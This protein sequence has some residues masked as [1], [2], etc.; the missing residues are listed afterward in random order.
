MDETDLELEEC[1]VHVTPVAV[2][3]TMRT[4]DGKVRPLINQSA[5]YA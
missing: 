3:L 4:T 5:R 1:S 2:V